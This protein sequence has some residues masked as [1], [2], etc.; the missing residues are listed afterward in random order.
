MKITEIRKSIS[1]SLGFAGAVVADNLV[2]GTALRWTNCA[3]AAGT[4]LL[5]YLV[6]NAKPTAASGAVN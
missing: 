6:P 1:A 4:L 2:S 5:V 3:I